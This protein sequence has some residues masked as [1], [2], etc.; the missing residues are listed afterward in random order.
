M[1]DGG[2]STYLVYLFIQIAAPTIFQTK[3]CIG[4]EAHYH[5]GWSSALSDR[6]CA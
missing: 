5:K 4:G 6:F 2:W 1:E 3:I